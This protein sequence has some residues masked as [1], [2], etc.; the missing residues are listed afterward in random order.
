VYANL[1][2][3]TA[4]VSCKALRKVFFEWYLKWYLHC[5]DCNKVL[6]KNQLNS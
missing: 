1:F 3:D 2:Y 4:P 6:S 5:Q